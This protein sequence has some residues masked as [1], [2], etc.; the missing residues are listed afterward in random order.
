MRAIAFACLACVCLAMA[1]AGAACSE[2]FPAAVL[3]LDDAGSEDAGPLESSPPAIIPP[4]QRVNAS[5]SPVVFDAV[6][7]GV[8]TA[9]GDVGTVSYVDPDTR[10]LVQEIPVGTDITSVALSP[11]G[12]WLAAVDRA[13]GN[14]SLLDADSRVVRRTIPL[15]SHPRACVWDPANPRWVYVVVEDAGTMVVV[16]RT[17]GQVVDTVSVGRLPSGLAVSA[18]QTEAFVTHRID[19]DLTVVDLSTRTVGADVAL[20]DEPFTADTVPNGKPLGFES[21]AITSDGRRAWIPHELLAPT[22]PI[23]FDE[24]LF[25]AISVVDLVEQVEV[26]T[27]PNSANI[28]GR[29]NL[30]DAI[31]ILGPDGQPEVFSQLC[32]VAMHPKGF[33]GWAVACGSEDLLVFDVTQGI[34]IDAIRNQ[35]GNPLGDHPMGLTLD[36]TGQRVFVLSDQSH[37]LETFDTD[38]GNLVGHTQV[39]GSPIPLVGKDPID[40]QLRAGITLFFR[41]NPDKGTLT[42]TN[43]DWMS[44]GGCHL[45]GF[46]SP[47]LRLFESMTPHDPASDAQ[48][49]HIGLVDLFS[50]TP[51]PLA[52]TFNP[53]DVLVA[54]TDQGGLVPVGGAGAAVSPSAPTAEATLMA[55]QLAAVVA[56]DLP[57]QPTWTKE[58]GGL[59]NLA[60]DTQYCGGCHPAEYADW[61]VSVHAHAGVDPMVTYCVGVEQGVAG[62]QFGRLCAGCHDPVGARTGDY[63]FQSKRGVTCLGC[64]DVELSLQVGGNAGLEATP[65]DWSTDHKAWGLASLETLRQ[66][67]FCGGCHEQFVPGTGLSV[68]STAGEYTSGPYSGQTLCVDCH[69]PKTQ[70]VADHRAAGGNV[71]LGQMYGDP[72]LLQEQTSHVQAALTVDA[73]SVAG[74]VLVTM[75]NTGAGHDFPTGVTDIKQAWVQIEAKDAS[76]AVVATYGGLEGGVVPSSAARLGIDFAQAD[77]TV[78]LRHELTQATRIPFDVRIPPGEAQALFVPVPPQPAGTTLEAAVEFAVVRPTYYRFAVD[79]PDAAAPTIEMS[80]TAVR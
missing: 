33:L 26:E 17:L 44:C 40:P 28:D 79:D 61:Q 37:T 50:T 45:D 47:N 12:V 57:L 54:V 11:D 46:G 64:H 6:R 27:D 59:P 55:Q 3:P 38:D 67:T 24:T 74:G 56:R 80:R 75:R 14:L 22:H 4:A 30:F 2:Q 16:D 10:T 21:L 76:G 15:G 73:Q 9:N 25:P 41:A 70:G 66:P 8:W 23:V 35:T 52:P 78:L 62:P 1:A 18:T 32:G 72:R 31:D 34:A 68:I 20:A 58:V 60:W 77:G 29:K 19:G 53:H 36:D 71:Y 7:G 63:S 69:M 48:I 5:S 49:G 13:G 42:T 39:Y 65:H 51:A 43:N